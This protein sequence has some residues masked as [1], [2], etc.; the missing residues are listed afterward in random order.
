MSSAPKPLEVLVVDDDPFAQDMARESLDALG[1]MEITCAEDGIAA[2]RLLR[3]GKVLPDAL[4][5]DIYMPNMD[6]LEFLEQLAR[7]QFKGAV[8]IVSGVNIDMLDMARQIARTNGL[9]VTGAFVKPVAHAQW[10]D[11]LG[12][13]P[14]S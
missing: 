12:L 2:L 3:S 6:G 5:C 8:I 13:N 9:E 11:A 4:V 1:S 14:V 7:M 10:A